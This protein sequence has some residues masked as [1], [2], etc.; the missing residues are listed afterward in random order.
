[1]NHLVILPILIPLV[2]AALSLFVEHRRYG[3]RVQRTVSFSALVLLA[4]AVAQLF[5]ET[6]DGTTQ[7]YL[8]GDWPSRLGIALV[9]D[10]LSVW[11]LVTTVLLAGPCLL[12]AC[13][14]WDRRAPH[15]HALYQFQLAGLNGAFLT[16]DIFNLFVFFEVML[17]ASYGLLLSGGR[18][19]RMRIGL[20]YV[21]FNVT[22]STLFLVALGLLYA[23]LGS[24]NMAELAQRIAEVPESHQALVKATLGLLM[25]VFCS[26]AALLP[27]YLWLPEAY[28][29][30][31]AAVAALFAIM[32][33]VGLY[34]LLRVQMLWFGDDAGALAGYGRD[35]LL[36]AGIA[37]LVLGG[38]G[39]LAATRLRVLIS[40]LVVV[41]AATLFVAFALGNE[42][43]VSAGLY[44]LPHSTFVAAALF[45]IADLIRRR[46]GGASDRKEVVA[47]MPGKT[48]PGVLFL[49]AAV[50]I[51]A[52][53][54]LSGFLAKAA[55]LAA[56]P[57]AS[58]GAV[59]AAVLGSGFMVIMGV[60]RAG[61]RLFWRVP[62]AEEEVLPPPRR[63]PTR[64]AEVAAVAMLLAWGV[65]MTV[66]AGPLMQHTTATAA[67]LLQ[68][69]QYV[70]GLRA[71]PP[72]I[73][74]P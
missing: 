14:G 7:A 51:T 54:P 10:R 57:E 36:W 24:L 39:V 60:T 31:P 37:T 9:A 49:V 15:F 44:Y 58:T 6:R 13:S 33:K 48:V 11:M 17:I 62:G 43:V 66:F 64:P 50:S 28:A 25:L 22:A 55:L 46:R 4:C 18:G 40:Y 26:K 63:A 8:L 23:S 70:E 45:L 42:G 2:G 71:T 74:Q 72:E 27:L 32:T 59:W 67:Q 56:V 34:A 65:L 69:G 61:I 68:P 41:S 21:V 38:F 73:R 47:P 52:L 1:M 53:P 3:P 12:H 16:G 19:L 29:R 30:A 35:W 20:H 5:A